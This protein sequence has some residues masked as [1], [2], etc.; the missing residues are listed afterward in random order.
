MSFK[1]LK[2]ITI[3][4]ILLTFLC[5]YNINANEVN[6]VA[7]VKN[8]II[9]STD[10][11]NEINYLLALNNEMKDLNKNTIYELAKRSMVNE[12]VKK[13]ELLKYFDFSKNTE[14]FEGLFVNF[15]QT[16]NF[17]NEEDFADYLKSFDLKISDVK[18][19]IQIETLWNELIY[20][21]YKSKVNI[22]IEKI[23]NELNA[24]KTQ[25]KTLEYLLSEIVFKINK[26]DE[27]KKTYN[28]ISENIKN[29][30]FKNTAN[31]YSI[32][33]TAK[34]GGNIGWIQE[35]QLSEEIKK[36]VKTLD[37]DEWSEPIKVS[38]GFLILKLSE[39][40]IINKDVN[41]EEA[42]KKII[43]YR[44]DKQLTQYSLIYFN[45]I[46]YNQLENE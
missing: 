32:S 37:I 3:I 15:F 16:M 35:N 29:I 44:T 12:I 17:N 33:S 5:V 1:I 45:K 43:K 27:L 11:N 8:E 14:V 4:P 28:E 30:G 41:P 21:K 26:I 40:K 24:A 39:K 42:L 20:G 7:K 38:N 25:E 19:K 13:Q 10:I 34:L 36:I 31:I 2:K 23:K 46:K 22:D 18:K 9:T 6:I